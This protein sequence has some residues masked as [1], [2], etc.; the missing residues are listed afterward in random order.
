M[1]AIV[2]NIMSETPLGRIEPM[3]N[4]RAGTAGRPSASWLAGLGVLA[5]SCSA[6]ATTIIDWHSGHPSNHNPGSPVQAIVPFDDGSGP[7]TCVGGGFPSAGALEAAGVACWNG[8]A[9]TPLGARSA[10]GEAF[11]L[12]VANGALWAGRSGGV[13]RWNGSSWVPAGPFQASQVNALASYRGQVHAAGFFG[14]FQAH[15][16]GIARWTGSRW[17]TIGRLPIN[18]LAELL[19]VDDALVVGGSFTTIDNRPAPGLARWDGAQW[20]PWPSGCDGAIRALAQGPQGLVVAGDFQSCGGEPTGPVARWDGSRWQALG[21]DLPGPVR[22][23]AIHDH[24]VI[25]AGVHADADLPEAWVAEWGDGR[26]SSLAERTPG[27]ILAIAAGPA[28]LEIAGS[29]A[30]SADIPASNVARRVAGRWLPYATGAIEGRVATLLSHQGA[31]YAGGHFIV[32]GDQPIRHLARWDGR[33]WQALGSTL[34]ASVEALAV[35]GGRLHAGG[36]FTAAG[37]QTLRHVARLDGDWQP[38]ADGTAW[39][40]HGLVPWR[41]GL[42]AREWQFSASA[43]SFRLRIWDGEVW[44]AIAPDQEIQVTPP[45]AVDGSLVFAVLGPRPVGLPQSRQIVA[46]NGSSL[47]TVGEPFWDPPSALA[48][49]AGALFATGPLAGS[50]LPNTNFARYDGSAWQALPASS[51]RAGS[52]GQVFALHQGE[53]WAGGSFRETGQ[54]GGRQ[55]ARWTGTRFEPVGNDIGGAL[56]PVLASQGARLIAGRGGRIGSE[57]ITAALVAHGPALATSIRWQDPGLVVAGMTAILTVEVEAANAPRA[58]HL[59]VIGIPSGACTAL[60]PERLDARRSRYRC[61]LRWTRPGPQAL[62]AFYSGGGHDDTAWHAARS[63]PYLVD[64]RAEPPLFKSGFE[65]PGH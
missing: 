20:M 33:S 36:S 38:L 59:S 26:W 47:A 9:W 14:E 61:K 43:S 29:F 4:G 58:G 49:H 55:L 24:R 65:P 41:N 2:R 35:Y 15:A 57:A 53:L 48:S 7:R 52:N 34:D 42:V 6:G 45:I 23:L 54:P 64:V 31:L 22:A 27:L 10:A 63:Q 21:A 8:S 39:P 13:E 1:S 3:R 62:T 28:G 40:V 11:A 17:E 46:W 60:D 44:S 30:A 5:A 19:V 37:S 25:A 18:V 32:P 50:S 16:P 51:H 12:L 56:G